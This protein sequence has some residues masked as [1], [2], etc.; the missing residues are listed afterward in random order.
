MEEKP[1]GKKA[2]CVLKN[3]EK[4]PGVSFFSVHIKSNDDHRVRSFY[5]PTAL[6]DC[7][8]IVFTLGVRMGGWR[9]EVCPACI[10]E[11]VRLH[12]KLILGMDIG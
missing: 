4:K 12:R 9:E 7:R 3:M 1:G 2:W 10:S 5:Y 11:T 8:G 6:K